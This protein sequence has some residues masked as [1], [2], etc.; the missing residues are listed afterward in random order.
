MVPVWHIITNYIQPVAEKKRD[1]SKWTFS[2]NHTIAHFQST[3]HGNFTME[4]VPKKV[5][6]LVEMI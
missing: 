3:P 4:D 5:G 1:T 2:K 6:Q